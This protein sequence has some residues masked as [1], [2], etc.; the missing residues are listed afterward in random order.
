LRRAPVTVGG[1]RTWWGAMPLL[2]VTGTVAASQ[3]INPTVI[4][5]D[6]TCRKIL[7]QITQG[8][9]AIRSASAV[10]VMAGSLAVRSGPGIRDGCREY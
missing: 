6:V 4:E 1:A 5:V 2:P 9:D 3:V 7:A 10:T 8:N